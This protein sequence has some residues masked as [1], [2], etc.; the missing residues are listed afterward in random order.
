MNKRWAEYLVS[1]VDWKLNWDAH[2][3]ERAN[4]AQDKVLEKFKRIDYECG[5]VRAEIL[6]DLEQAADTC[7]DIHHAA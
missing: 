3:Y 6:I 7:A 2:T 5:K 1:G 4:N